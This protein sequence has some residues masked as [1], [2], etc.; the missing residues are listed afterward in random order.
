MPKFVFLSNISKKWLILA[1]LIASLSIFTLAYSFNQ[2]YRLDRISLVVLQ[3]SV[4]KDANNKKNIIPASGS[5]ILPGDSIEISKDGGVVM[6]FHDGST[7]SFKAGESI[8]YTSFDFK[9]QRNHFSFIKTSN[10]NESFEYV[11][12]TYINKAGAVILGKQDANMEGTQLNSK[13]LGAS[14]KVKSHEE[15]IQLWDNLNKCIQTGKD[16]LLYPKLIEK[17]MA[18]NNIYTLES[19]SN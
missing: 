10:N 11:T 1:G 4:I 14:E 5:V 16:N 13:V 8:K 18:E 6:I 19:L 3:G 15:K 12:D 9:D 2:F 7:L 17:C